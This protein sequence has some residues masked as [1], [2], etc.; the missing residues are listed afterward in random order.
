MLFKLRFPFLCVF[1]ATS[2]AGCS[3]YESEG[4]KLFESQGRE[5]ISLAKLSPLTAQEFNEVTAL[6]FGEC[7]TIKAG[8]ARLMAHP[9]MTYWESSEEDY[10]FSLN[11]SNRAEYVI[12]VPKVEARPLTLCF[13]AQT[14]S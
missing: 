6:G 4:R 9:D 7:A 10:L 12:I 13:P 14:S 3:I 5:F 1:L 11:S 2:L 8:R